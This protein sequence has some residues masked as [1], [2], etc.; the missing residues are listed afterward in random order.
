MVKFRITLY[1]LLLSLLLVYWF[2][3]YWAFIPVWIDL[4]MTM[5]VKIIGKARVYAWVQSL[6]KSQK[7]DMRRKDL[8]RQAKKMGFN[9]KGILGIRERIRLRNQA[10]AESGIPKKEALKILRNENLDIQK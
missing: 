8:A 6:K 1:C 9:E 3:W 10:I 4:S 2:T 5:F 7:F